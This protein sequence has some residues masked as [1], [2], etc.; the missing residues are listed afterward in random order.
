MQFIHIPTTEGGWVDRIPIIYDSDDDTAYYGDRTGNHTDMMW[1]IWGAKGYLDKKLMHKDLCYLAWNVTGTLTELN[2]YMQGGKSIELEKWL[3]QN[4][5]KTA[6]WDGGVSNTTLLS[7]E[8]A[9]H[10]A[11]YGHGQAFGYVNGQLYFGTNHSKITTAMIKEGWDYQQL[12]EAPQVWGW[13]RAPVNSRYQ[14]ENGD[15]AGDVPEA[16]FG[17]DDKWMENHTYGNLQGEATQAL[18]VWWHNTHLAAT[19]LAFKWS[20]D[21][22]QK[23]GL[24]AD[25]CFGYVDGHLVF[26]ETHHQLI[27]A[28]FLNKGWTWA[29][30][31]QAPQCWGWFG[32]KVPY[33]WSKG[34]WDDQHPKNQGQNSEAK[35]WPW[36]SVSFSS[37]AG[38]Q[39]EGAIKNCIQT[40]QYLYKLPVHQTNS[41]KQVDVSSFGSGLRGTHNIN[42]Y[43]QGGQYQHLADRIEGV[44]PP[45]QDENAWNDQKEHR[46][47][48]LTQAQAAGTLTA[49]EEAEFLNLWIE[50]ESEPKVP[51]PPK[52]IVPTVKSPPDSAEF[53]AMVNVSLAGLQIGD[54]F[55]NSF[56]P[57][58]TVWEKA[59]EDDGTGYT[60][61]KIV[62]TI[63]GNSFDT[64]KTPTNHIYKNLYV[65]KNA[66]QT[67][68]F[69]PNSTPLGQMPVGTHFNV[70]WDD[71][72]KV[73]GPPNENGQ[74]PHTH[75]Q[76]GLQGDSGQE[77]IP[78]F[79][80]PPTTASWKEGRAFKIASGNYKFVWADGIFEVAAG[81]LKTLHHHV[82]LDSIVSKLGEMPKTFVAGDYTESPF[83]PG[84][85]TVSIRWHEGS[86][87][88]S[89]TELGNMM[90][91]YLRHQQV[92]AKIEA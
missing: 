85:G 26:G 57:N 71:V 78:P 63:G 22:W 58:G 11:M 12:L 34:H 62:Y 46:L 67:N 3:R 83:H 60:P 10:N 77:W 2:G 13:V 4:L 59:G 44:P 75:L 19:K 39:N 51:E 55:K 15:P 52:Q 64:T 29:Q 56:G 40:F 48:E 70:G 38:F 87:V 53:I 65:K 82:I 17:S 43:L 14:I 92:T 24:K 23:A 90:Q 45:P 1:A 79:T 68:E 41:F 47:Q 61:L 37:D 74:V 35:S 76:S 81:F 54:Q 31:S 16:H 30:L 6:D 21:H 84:L 9:K 91:D 72:W 18:D 7:P 36:I 25:G 33:E 27:M 50:H 42:K 28:A 32:V 66:I 73:D 20:P 69:V 49:D 88:P 5:M 86:P 8:A 89:P 80:K